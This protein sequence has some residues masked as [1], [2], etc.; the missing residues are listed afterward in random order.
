MT[1]LLALVTVALLLTARP[2]FAGDLTVR[3][4]IELHKS[5]LSDELLIAVIEA[6]GEPFELAVAEILDLRAD[7]LSERV[8]A[9]MVRTGSRRSGDRRDAG[10]SVQQHV[11]QVAPTVVVIDGGSPALP[12]TYDWRPSTFKPEPGQIPPRNPPATWTTRRSDGRN[13]TQDREVSSDKPAASWV[14][15]RGGG[16]ADTGEKKPAS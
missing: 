11:T 13:V 2:L 8:I 16:K 15:P 10:V 1:R 7:G 14:T 3:D 4:V 6:N 5:G 9:A 12:A